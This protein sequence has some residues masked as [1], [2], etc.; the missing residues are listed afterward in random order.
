MGVVGG[1]REYD[2]PGLGLGPWKCP[3]CRAENSGPI[4]A[5]C[6]SCGSGSA[7]ARHVGVS[8]PPVSDLHLPRPPIAGVAGG[9]TPSPSAIAFVQWFGVQ[10]E[11]RAN[12]LQ[13]AENESLLREAFLVGYACAVRDLQARTMAAPPVTADVESLAPEGKAR[14]T[15]VAALELFKDQVLRGA[16]D[17]IASGEW[18]SIE[19]VEQLIETLKN[20]ED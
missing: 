2:G 20:Q 16:T 10:L 19:E 3:S 14:R 13:L 11:E 1:S 4:D 12:K 9:S 18:C 8:P 15:I 5:G 6:V 7:P 17:E